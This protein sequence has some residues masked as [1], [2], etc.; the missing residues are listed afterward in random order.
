MP[1]CQCAAAG[2]CQTHSR[3][4]SGNSTPVERHSR[5][6]RNSLNITIGAG[7]LPTVSP[8][9]IPRKNSVE[10]KFRKNRR[11]S[12]PCISNFANSTSLK[13]KLSKLRSANS[14]EEL[15]EEELKEEVENFHI[16]AR[17]VSVTSYRVV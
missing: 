11:Q 2:N 14:S 15:N 10:V 7:Q 5:E 4:T 16:Q 8:E 3:Q 6:R 9:P 13:E 17:K 1:N 12:A